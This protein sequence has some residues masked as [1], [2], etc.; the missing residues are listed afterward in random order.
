MQVE[1]GQTSIRVSKHILSLL[2]S[3]KTSSKDSYD[4]IIW[5]LIEPHL[6]LNEKTKKSIEESRKEYQRG[7]YHTLDEIKKMYGL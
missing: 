5:D 4:D 1:A 3:M 6:E 7:E 2:Q